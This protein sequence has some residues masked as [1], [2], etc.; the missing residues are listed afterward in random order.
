MRPLAECLPFIWHCARSRKGGWGKL[1]IKSGFAVVAIVVV[2]AV[3]VAGVAIA[4]AVAAAAFVVFAAAVVVVAAALA[5]VIIVAVNCGTKK[6]SHE[7][8]CKTIISLQNGH[9]V[10]VPRR[11]PLRPRPLL[12][13][14]DTAPCSSRSRDGVGS[15]TTDGIRGKLKKC[16]S[17]HNVPKKYEVSHFFSPHISLKKQCF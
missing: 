10:P 6:I 9:P 11:L 4:A 7:D 17:I 13:R 12:R 2:A 8:P 3:V 14:G 15:D 1:C 16:K 5:T